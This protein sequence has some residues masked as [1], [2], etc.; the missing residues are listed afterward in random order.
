M[1]YE[2]KEYGHIV[3]DME[4]NVGNCLKHHQLPLYR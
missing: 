3:E 1:K 4:N 2:R